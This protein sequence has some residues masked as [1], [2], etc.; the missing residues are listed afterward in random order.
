MNK[1]SRTLF[2]RS[3]EW[4]AFRQTLLE[5]RGAVCTLCGQ[6]YYGKNK[7]NLHIHHLD[8]NPEHYDILD[9]VKFTILCKQ[10]HKFWHKILRRKNSKSPLRNSGLWELM[11]K[12]ITPMS[13]TLVE[14][15]DSCFN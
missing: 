8:P 6:E 5:D 13:R 7:K 2:L 4:K 10:C 3:A 9:P 14:D 15:T 12:A 1:E 11:L